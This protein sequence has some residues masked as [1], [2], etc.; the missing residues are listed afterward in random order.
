MKKDD[1]EQKERLIREEDGSPEVGSGTVV[2][3]NLFVGETVKNNKALDDTTSD[4]EQSDDENKLSFREED[5]IDINEN[6]LLVEL[7]KIEESHEEHNSFQDRFLMNYKTLAYFFIVGFVVFLTGTTCF[8]YIRY[9][10]NKDLLFRLGRSPTP[11]C[12]LH[13]TSE[14]E[15]DKKWNV[16]TVVS[17]NTTDIVFAPKYALSVSENVIIQIEKSHPMQYTT[18]AIEKHKIHLQSKKFQYQLNIMVWNMNT[19]KRDDDDNTIPKDEYY[20]E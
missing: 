11:V 15:V 18:K 7:K 14:K 4:S 13:V 2:D 3:M 16:E 12:Y 19:L 17:T 1:E 8:N 10:E 20:V 9:V 5:V 6:K